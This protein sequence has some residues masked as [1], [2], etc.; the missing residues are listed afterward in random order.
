MRRVQVHL[1]G[2]LYFQSFLL[3]NTGFMQVPDFIADFL[4]IRRPGVLPGY[5]F[6]G[7][8]LCQ[9]STST[10]LN[11]FGLLIWIWLGS[12]ITASIK[13]WHL[14]QLQSESAALFTLFI[15]SNMFSLKSFNPLLSGPI[16]Q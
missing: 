7:F 4:T 16:S 15:M 11:S 12:Q 6:V 13:W 9:G 14:M 8:Y 1:P 5:F 2:P 3:V 10:C